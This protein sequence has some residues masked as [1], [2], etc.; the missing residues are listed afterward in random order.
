MEPLLKIRDLHAGYG[1]IKA[2]RG[3]KIAVQG[4]M[5][6]LEFKKGTTR[7]FLLVRNQSLCCFG[8]MP[9]MNEWVKVEMVN[10]KRASFI[11]DQPVT[12][13]GVF[14]VGEE[15]LHGN[16]ASIYRMTSEQVAGPLDL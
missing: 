14:D 6:P 5:V 16:V 12:V 1:P 9:A 7:S 11:N 15:I 4:F 10:E 8:R 13:Y 2:L 3:K